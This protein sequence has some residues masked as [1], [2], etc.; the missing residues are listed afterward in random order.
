M[1]RAGARTRAALPA[2]GG[3]WGWWGGGQHQRSPPFEAQ[4]SR[5]AGCLRESLA[6][7]RRGGG[8]LHPSFTPCA[9]GLGARSRRRGSCQRRLLSGRSSEATWLC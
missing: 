9:C 5:R 2:T 8:S 1:R 6:E 4:R 3:R 7:A